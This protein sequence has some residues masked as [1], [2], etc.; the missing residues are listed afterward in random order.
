MKKFMEKHYET[1]TDTLDKALEVKMCLNGLG[2]KNHFIIKE[3]DNGYILE[4]W[5]ESQE[6]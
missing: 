5:F 6:K 1:L 3:V 4:I 2:F